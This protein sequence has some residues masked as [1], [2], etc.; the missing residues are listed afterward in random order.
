[1]NFGHLRIG[2]ERGP[3][4]FAGIRQEQ[5][6]PALSATAFLVR[7]LIFHHQNTRGPPASWGPL[8]F[9]FAAIVIGDRGR[10]SHRAGVGPLQMAE[11]RCRLNRLQKCRSNPS[12]AWPCIRSPGTRSADR[13]RVIADASSDGRERGFGDQDRGDDNDT[14]FIDYGIIRSWLAVS[15]LVSGRLIC[16]RPPS[17]ACQRGASGTADFN[18]P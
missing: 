2:I 6:N 7:R 4:T 8:G 1:M 3:N 10:R 16:G 17:I 12:P 13:R 14:G 5:V 9:A 11:R 18:P 15:R